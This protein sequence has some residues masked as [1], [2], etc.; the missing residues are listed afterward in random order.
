MEAAAKENNA[1]QK[2]AG[3][4]SAPVVHFEL[5]YDDRER[6]AKFYQEAFNWKTEML[7]KEMGDYV[8]ATTTDSDRNGPKRPGAI[9]GGFFERKPDRPGQ[10]PS[11]VIAVDD[12]K[13]AMKKVAAAGG[14]VFGQPVEIPGIGEYVAFEDSEGNRLS[15]LKPIPR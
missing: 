2:E 11:M 5:P 7:G 14:K 15:L 12:I 10:Y 9:N 13:A 1:Q 3:Q 6:M 8:V 4:Q